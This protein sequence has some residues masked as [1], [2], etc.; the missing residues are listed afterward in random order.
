MSGRRART[1]RRDDTV[2]LLEVIIALPGRS[3][4]YG[5]A[6]VELC[7]T[8]G[9]GNGILK[10]P[11]TPVGCRTDGQDGFLELGVF[12]LEDA[13]HVNLP[14][15]KGSL[16]ELA[17]LSADLYT[18]VPSWLWLARWPFRVVDLGSR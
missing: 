3:I 18:R 9:F 2:M 5:S 15:S 6:R 10:L 11:L 16:G 14:L 7:D 17:T 12:V 4:T 8:A 13:Y 1:L